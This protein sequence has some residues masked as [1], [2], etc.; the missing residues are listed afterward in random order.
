MYHYHCFMQHLDGDVSDL[1]L[2]FSWD[3]NFMGKVSET[4]PWYGRDWVMETEIII[5]LCICVPLG[6]T[7]VVTHELIPGG[8]GIPVTNENRFVN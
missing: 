2:T 1:C 8:C 4:S 7:Q 5:H 6:S 3:E